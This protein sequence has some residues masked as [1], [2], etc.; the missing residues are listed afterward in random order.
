MRR[1]LPARADPTLRQPANIQKILR[2]RVSFMD[3]SGEEM[4]NGRAWVARHIVG[5]TISESNACDNAVIGP[6]VMVRPRDHFLPIVMKKTQVFPHNIC[7][8]TL[9]QFRA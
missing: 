4:R 8:K 7:S 3:I 2:I 5:L 1:A 6:G 9:L